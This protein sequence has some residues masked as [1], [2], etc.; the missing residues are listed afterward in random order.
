MDYR[1][2]SLYSGRAYRLCKILGE[3]TGEAL[4]I[5]TDLSLPS[6]GVIPVLEQLCTL[7]GRPRLPC[8]ADSLDF[9]EGA[10]TEWALQHGIYI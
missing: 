4:A 1:C 5:E 3:G 8:S 6:V 2:N 7:F 9:L 10:T